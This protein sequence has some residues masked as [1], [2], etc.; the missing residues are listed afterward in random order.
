MP[1][2]RRRFTALLI[3]SIIGVTT[4]SC[5]FAADPEQKALVTETLN[6][7]PDDIV[8]A[9][10]LGE[11]RLRSQGKSGT[12]VSGERSIGLSPGPAP[13]TTAGTWVQ[14]CQALVTALSG[15]SGRVY[16]RMPGQDALHEAT[17]DLCRRGIGHPLG[18]FGVPQ[19]ILGLTGA[20]GPA[21]DTTIDVHAA[22]LLLS[23]VGRDPRPPGAALDVTA[24]D[25]AAWDEALAGEELPWRYASAPPPDTETLTSATFVV[26]AG[27]A[28]RAVVD[29]GLVAGNTHARI[30][31]RPDGTYVTFVGGTPPPARQ[32][33]DAAVCGTRLDHELRPQL[34]YTTT[35]GDRVDRY[36]LVI[37]PALHLARTGEPPTRTV[38]VDRVG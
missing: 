17:A 21:T 30:G 24:P 34:S 15:T 33:G 12:D 4:T 23:T 38:T 26:P 19:L 2:L 28:L 29:C 13:A 37:S 6:G 27:T 1:S 18:N 8:S 7:I 31:P 22:D 32:E 3:V 20:D 11:V 25:P 5:G 14:G 10:S 36:E 35:D 9:L 16:G